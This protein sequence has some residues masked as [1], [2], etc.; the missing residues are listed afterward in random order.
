MAKWLQEYIYAIDFTQKFEFLSW[1]YG[2]LTERLESQTCSRRKVYFHFWKCVWHSIFHTDIT[3]KPFISRTFFY[4]VWIQQIILPFELGSGKG[5]NLA[6]CHTKN[7]VS[8]W[9]ILPFGHTNHVNVKK[10]KA[11]VLPWYDLN[12]MSWKPV[13][14]PLW[15]HWLMALGVTLKSFSWLYINTLWGL[16]SFLQAR[17]MQYGSN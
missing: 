13:E 6:K 11:F 5:L 4:S 15:W 16:K 17:Q 1:M 14:W 7:Q 9:K 12:L 10:A 3:V 8:T 2:K